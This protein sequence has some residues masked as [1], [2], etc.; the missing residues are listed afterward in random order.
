MIFELLETLLDFFFFVVKK[1]MTNPEDMIEVL[2]TK[3]NQLNALVHLLG[4]PLLVVKV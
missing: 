2:C 3:E 1:Q 4:Q